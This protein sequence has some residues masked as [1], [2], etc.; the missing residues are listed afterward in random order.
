VF[1]ILLTLGEMVFS[2]L[3]NSFISKFSPN[4]LLT[5]MMSVWVFVVFIAGKSYGWIY[6]FTLQFPFAPTY[7]IIAAIAIGA[8]AILWGLDKKLSGLVT[9][10]DE[11]SKSN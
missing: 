6:E 1:G 3:G 10:R 4:R 2:P 9:E 8:G 5:A 11:T 7:F